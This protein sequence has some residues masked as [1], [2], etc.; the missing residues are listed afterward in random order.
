MMGAAVAVYY[1]YLIKEIKPGKPVD[2][3]YK[4]KTSYVILYT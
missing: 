1:Y 4:K 2:P 3:E